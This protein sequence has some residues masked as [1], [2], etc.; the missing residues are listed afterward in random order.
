MLLRESEAARCCDR[1]SRI[2]PDEF[3]GCLATQFLQT[4]ESSRAINGAAM[5]TNTV[6]CRTEMSDA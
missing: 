5:I 6:L 4:A 1:S 2:R 3:L